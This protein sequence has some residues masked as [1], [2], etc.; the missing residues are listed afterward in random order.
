MTR[1]DILQNIGSR[2]LG[3]RTSLRVRKTEMAN[4]LGISISGYFKNEKGENCPDI[5]TF[6]VLADQFDLSLDWLI[7]GRGEEIY[8]S[9]AEIKEELVKEMEVAQLEEAAPEPDIE[10][11]KEGL[12]DDIKELIDHMEHIPLLR[13]EVLTMFHKFK[14]SKKNM[15]EETMKTGKE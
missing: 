8:K 5:T 9:P 4:R 11:G 6:Q 1:K 2:L 12:R 15:V 7:M 14:E 3:I 13:Y 10:P